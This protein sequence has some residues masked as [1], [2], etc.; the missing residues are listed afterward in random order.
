M[1]T[2]VLLWLKPR[3]SFKILL[4]CFWKELPVIGFDWFYVLVAASI[5]FDVII[6]FN[7]VVVLIACYLYSIEQVG[8]NLLIGGKFIF[9][10]CF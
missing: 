7:D 10:Y 6:S 8:L 2:L 4:F 9:S 1:F 3:L 5:L